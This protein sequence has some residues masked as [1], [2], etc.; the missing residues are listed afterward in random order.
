M[1]NRLT[2]TVLIFFILS[3]FP[4]TAQSY[5]KWEF[6]NPADLQITISPEKN[7]IIAGSVAT[8][9][10]SI[11]N[12]TD[13]TVKI[14][15]PTGQH[16]DLAAYHNRTQIFRW[17][18]GLLWAEAPHIIPLKTGETTSEKLSWTTVDRH[19]LP[20]PQGV[21]TVHGMVMTSPRFLVSNDCSIRLLPPEIKKMET[22]DAVLNQMFEITL[23]R[24]SGNRELIWKIDYVYND[25]RIAV[26]QT[27][28]SDKELIITFQPKR[29]G[30]VEFH[31]YG[32]RDTQDET[33]ALE[34]R[35]F[36]VEV[37]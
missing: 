14:S 2:F 12:R 3:A 7:E 31:L 33:I 9:T 26:H 4:L 30:H 37:K 27:R 21:Y 19:G 8:F 6:V 25:N 15:Y 22:I 18:Q 17:S 23:P 34:R 16:W 13:K 20:L 11:R 36:R 32:Y 1:K 28:K 29:V 10:I 35:S 24:Y 5:R